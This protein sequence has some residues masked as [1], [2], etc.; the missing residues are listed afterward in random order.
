MKRENGFLNMNSLIFKALITILLSPHQTIF[1][2]I[3]QCFLRKK[4]KKR[5]QLNYL[6]IGRKLIKKMK[7]DNMIIFL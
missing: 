2:E 6:V 3:L 4:K 1:T 5:S 7:I